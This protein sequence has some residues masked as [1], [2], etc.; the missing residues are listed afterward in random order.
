MKPLVVDE[1][2]QDLPSRPQIADG[3]GLVME[4]EDPCPLL[5]SCLSANPCNQKYPDLVKRLNLNQRLL[6]FGLGTIRQ[7]EAMRMLIPGC[8][9]PARTG[10]LSINHVY[11]ELATMETDD[12]T[13]RDLFNFYTQGS[14]EY[15]A[16]L[17]TSTLGV[18][19]PLSLIQSGLGKIGPAF[20]ALL[21]TLYV[22]F[23]FASGFSLS[24]LIGNVW[25]LYTMMPSKARD[26]N[27][28]LASR[29]D[30]FNLGRRN[31]IMRLENHA[32]A[33]EWVAFLG[34][35]VFYILLLVSSLLHW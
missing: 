15:S 34:P 22:V 26:K 10:R 35:P 8:K 5:N 30:Y 32:K 20:A 7:F 19:A 21:I 31:R 33:I 6:G 13:K 16:L 25:L 18:L 24:R 17:L 3:R 14:L 11:L 9:R 12:Q 27:E 2:P 29:Y 28:E 1:A 23:S 4:L